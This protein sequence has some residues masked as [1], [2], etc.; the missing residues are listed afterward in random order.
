PDAHLTWVV[1]K[2][3][4]PLVAH[5]DAIDQVITLP[6]GFAKSP[7]LLL[8]LRRELKQQKFHFSLDP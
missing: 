3:S 1:E 5:C 8:R 2:G 7:R 6:K 4:A